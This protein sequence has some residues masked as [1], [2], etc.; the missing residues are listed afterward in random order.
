MFKAF[1]G[2][3]NDVPLS[4]IAYSTFRGFT[5]YYWKV[6]NVLLFKNISD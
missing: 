4:A 1:Y 6:E 3:S 2:F 5:L